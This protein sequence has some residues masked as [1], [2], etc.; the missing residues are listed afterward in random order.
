MYSVVLPIKISNPGYKIFCELGLK[1]YEKYLKNVE[2]FYI[3][4]PKE[5]TDEISKLIST[6]SL[7]F[8]IRNDEEFLKLNNETEGWFKQ[9]LLKLLAHK[10]VT[11]N[12]YIVVDADMFLTTELSYENL[13]PDGKVLYSSEP[14][15][16]IN[17]K[18]FS[19]NS[20][21]WIS[22]CSILNYRKEDLYFQTDLLGVTPQTFIVSIVSELINHL[23]NSLGENWQDILCE[24]RF[25]EFTLYWIYVLQTNSKHLYTNVS[26]IP[27]WKHDLLRNILDPHDYSPNF[28]REAF[29][30]IP[31]YFTVIQGYLIPQI[32]NVDR[33]LEEGKRYLN[34]K[35]VDCIVLTAS[36]IMPK[37]H[38]GF[39]SEERFLQTIET[40]NSIKKHIPNSISIL[41]EGSDIPPEYEEKL[42][43]E[44]DYVLMYNSDKEVQKYVCH[45]TNIGYG[46]CALLL[47]GVEFLLFDLLFLYNPKYILKLGGRYTLND[48][49]NLSNFNSKKFTFRQHYD[50]SVSQD[51]FTTGLYSIPLKYIQFFRDIL[52]TSLNT[53]YVMVEKLYKDAIP[54]EIIH[55]IDTL[56]LAGS[57]SYNRFFFEK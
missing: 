15:Q 52:K 35:D 1:S 20:N 29:I 5:N 33:F 23:N 41:I 45:P 3:L 34:R 17:G 46:E 19:Q 47:K 27:L 6:S 49:F 18:Y 43:K 31:S 22:S 55:I 13:H 37:R 4:C 54:S 30:Y 11:T 2:T 26:E 48:N 12:T 32:K 16:T 8:K 39:T 21:W 38:Q 40:R 44:Y 56:G 51:V 10:I 28:M 9:Q 7:P 53:Y 57:L 50:D 36:S 25:T 14:W 42:R 24:K